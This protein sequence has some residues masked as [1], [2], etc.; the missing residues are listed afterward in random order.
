MHSDN[1]FGPL[2]MA[3]KTVVDKYA[4]D[5]LVDLI[6]LLSSLACHRKAPAFSAPLLQVLKCLTSLKQAQHIDFVPLRRRRSDYPY[7]CGKIRKV[8]STRICLC[9]C[10]NSHALLFSRVLSRCLSGTRHSLF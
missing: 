4:A 5:H 3:V 1:D 6:M 2:L 10:V 8:G 7:K 9:A